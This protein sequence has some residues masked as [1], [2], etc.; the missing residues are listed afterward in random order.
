M[1]ILTITFVF[2]FAAVVSA[3]TAPDVQEQIKK[4]EAQMQAMQAELE[5]L[6]KATATPAQTA[7]TE[8]P[9]PAATPEKKAEPEKRPV[10]FE[11]GNGVR[12]V[13]YGT[14]YF[15]LFGNDAGTNNSDIPLFAATAGRGNTSASV[16][17]TRL[18]L[19]IEGL[20]IGNA[21]ITGVV[22]TDFYGGSPAISTGE[23]FGVVRVRL[24]NAK[25]DW[26]NTSVTIGQ[27]W[28]PFAP[29][30]PVSIADAAI[31]QF[32]AA[33]NNWARLPQVK[34]EERFADGR[35]VWQGAVLAPQTGDSNSTANFLQQPN[36]GALSRIP[37]FQTRL[38][39]ND[40]NWLGT[41]KAGTIGV[42]AHY[43]R[44]RAASTTAPIADFNVDS[45]GVALDWNFPLH[46][47]F[48]WV[49]EAF[50]GQ[51]LAGFQAGVF[52]NFNT[53]Y[54]VRVNNVLTPR[55]VRGIRTYGGWTQ[56]GITPKIKGDKLAFYAS[57][58]LD[59]P[60][61]SDLV[62]TRNRDFRTRNLAWAFDTIYK[63]TPQLQIGLEFR[64]L[65]TDYV[66]SG[67][68]RA[69]HVNLGAA[70]SF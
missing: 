45:Y 4:L 70:Y 67:R 2:L 57:I 19:R 50:F 37:F 36:S 41:K 3:Q 10:G 24:A 56:V 60:R 68:K 63:F 5:R 1:R 26:K 42:S 28:I 11:L 18:G 44:S 51:N 17:Q 61:N 12:A 55:G 35:I 38:G 25:I 47:R 33:G 30:N 29:Q 15:N 66:L 16:R 31:P 69:N 6:K 48:S 49:G 13:P 14:I 58:G 32:A 39:F 54:A 7:K 9:V 53:D 52:Q 34:I 27:D 8:T 59:D 22:E 65:N 20:K 23:N 40:K 64:Q 21:K 62:N 46:K 43:G